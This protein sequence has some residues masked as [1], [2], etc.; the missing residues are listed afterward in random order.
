MGPELPRHSVPACIAWHAQ[1]TPLAVALAEDDASVT[2]HDLAADVIRT[3]WQ[4][5]RYGIRSGLVLGIEHPR[6]YAHLLVI[7]AC[8]VIG[9]TTVSLAAADL[10]IGR[11]VLAQC[12]MVLATSAVP[13]GCHANVATIAAD[14]PRALSQLRVR[15][16]DLDLLCRPI[17]ANAIARITRSSGTTGKPKTMAISHDVMQRIIGQTIEHAVSGLAS[18]PQF[19]CLYT[20][21]V[22]AAYSR[23]LGTLML[24]G[25]V[26]F[27]KDDVALRL[28][29]MGGVNHALFI[30]GDMGHLL[31]LLPSPPAH[32]VMSV[33][34]IGGAVSARL[35]QS[36]RKR[37]NAHVIVKY[38]S[39]ETNRVSLIDDDN[40]GRLFPGVEVRITDDVG[41]DVPF[42]QTGLIRIKTQTMASGYNNDP[43]AS[44]AC[45]VDGWF[46]SNDIGYMPAPGKLVVLGRA[47]DVLNIGGLKI[48]PC[49]IEDQIKR[50]D[51]LS[52]AVVLG[53]TDADGTDVL[54]VALEL[55][56]DRPSSHL[57]RSIA[58]ILSPY[59]RP[60]EFIA[61][62]RFPRTEAGKV[63][64][65]QIRAMFVAGDKR[66]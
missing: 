26:H 50:I 61:M 64:R 29:A 56:G 15:A 60:C 44:A 62:G 57:P 43:V 21:G 28:I 19:L 48:A 47:D 25:A 6:A 23:V 24:G 8:S 27:A 49:E 58:P 31:P 4:L 14:Y 42:G 12:D 34:L 38:S 53:G 55:I 5:E 51:G 13:A 33:E 17:A 54:L 40:V 20:L 36:V 66:A 59:A 45:F 37:L 52:D 11:D 10:T 46:R 9:V 18:R 1:R 30:V 16:D 7:L 39:N 35:R 41:R 3:I 65:Q 63:K 32:H 22:R 2:Y